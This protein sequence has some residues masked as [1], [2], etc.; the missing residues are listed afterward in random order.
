MA[1]HNQAIFIQGMTST[2]RSFRP[3]D[4]AERLCGVMSCFRPDAAGP[5]AHLQYSPYCRPIMVGNI[6]CVVVDPRLQD[7]EPMAMKF[8][9]NFAKDNDLQVVDA[10]VMPDK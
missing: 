1:L 9:L 7:L 6:K 4:W 8:V 2:G 10:C 3:S 5:H